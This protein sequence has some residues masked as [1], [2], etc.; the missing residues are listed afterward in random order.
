MPITILALCVL[1]LVSLIIPQRER[2]S[3]DAPTKE[4]SKMGIVLEEE[5]YASLPVIF[6]IRRYPPP[7]ES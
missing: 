2:F 4:E 6:P 3:G 1:F 5:L 7:K